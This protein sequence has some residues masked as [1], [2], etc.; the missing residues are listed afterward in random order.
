MVDI[1]IKK[2]KTNKA[3]VKAIRIIKIV[4]IKIKGVS[5]KIKLKMNIAIAIKNCLKK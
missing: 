2:P 5:T 1:K 4:Q 3:M